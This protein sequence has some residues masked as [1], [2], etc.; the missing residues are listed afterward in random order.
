MAR[1]LPPAIHLALLPL[2]RALELLR[3]RRSSRR[4]RSGARPGIK[5]TM[6]MRRVGVRALAPLRYQ[7][8]CLHSTH[9]LWGRVLCKTCPGRRQLQRRL[10]RRKQQRLPRRV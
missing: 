9:P 4:S 1:R 6:G 3:R 8:L 7:G 2:P 10:Q 5:Q